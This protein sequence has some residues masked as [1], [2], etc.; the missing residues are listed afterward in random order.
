MTTTTTIYSGPVK[1]VNLFFV[2]ASVKI[3]TTSTLVK[4]TTLVCEVHHGLISCFRYYSRTLTNTVCNLHKS[5]KWILSLF[6]TRKSRL[7]NNYEICTWVQAGVSDRLKNWNPG[8][9]SSKN[10]C[11]SY[12][13]ILLKLLNALVLQCNL[14]SALKETKHQTALLI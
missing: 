11:S 6:H 10:L 12:Q 3:I 1:Y 2:L 14:P 4:I 8:L 5:P 7:K 13:K 9:S